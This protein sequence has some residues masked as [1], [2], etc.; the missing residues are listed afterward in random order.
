M[1][2]MRKI[3]GILQ[4]SIFFLFG[5]WL[6]SFKFLSETSHTDSYWIAGV[7]YLMLGVLLWILG[8]RYGWFVD[9]SNSKTD[10]SRGSS[11][12]IPFVLVIGLMSVLR[13][14]DELLNIDSLFPFVVMIIPLA[15]ILGYVGYMAQSTMRPSQFKGSMYRKALV[16]MLIIG[17]FMLAFS[18]LISANINMPN[19]QN[20]SR[21]YELVKTDCSDDYV[22]VNTKEGIRQLYNPKQSKSQRKECESAT[23]VKVK[24][25]MNIIGIDYFDEFEYLE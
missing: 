15:T 10:G 6:I 3:I 20:E 7:I 12:T 17:S 25:K 5:F 13:D 1:E 16:P 9:N 23:K 2:N 8:N 21:T 11:F 18:L 14:R 22:F 24:L 4:M 19:E